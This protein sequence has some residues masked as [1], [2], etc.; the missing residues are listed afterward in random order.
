MR[1][2]LCPVS[3]GIK[4]KKIG[5]DETGRWRSVLENGNIFDFSG[6]W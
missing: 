5:M 4:K 2:I 6:L 3:S 1:W